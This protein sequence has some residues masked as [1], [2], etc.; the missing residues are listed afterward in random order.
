M[1]A[2]CVGML[3]PCTDRLDDGHVARSER[4]DQGGEGEEEG[5]VPRGDDESHAQGLRLH[6][7]RAGVAEE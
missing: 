7:L 2:A 3:A 5:V 6:V 1:G 4:A